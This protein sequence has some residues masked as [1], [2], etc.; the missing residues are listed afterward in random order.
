MNRVRDDRG[1]VT[2]HTDSDDDSFMLVT[3]I[4]AVLAMVIG[5]VVWFWPVI[6]VDD[7]PTV[8]QQEQQD[9]P[10]AIRTVHPEDLDR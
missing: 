7:S 1:T 6:W 3:I 9:W 4:V 10:F 2:Q 5:L 8:Q